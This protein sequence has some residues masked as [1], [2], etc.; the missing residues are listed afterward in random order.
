[1]TIKLLETLPKIGKG[2]VH[3]Q[4]VRCGKPHCRCRHGEP[5]QAFYLFWRVDGKLR[6]RHIR[7]T[8]VDAIR[9]ACT[10]RRERERRQRQ[11]LRAW[12]GQ[13]SALVA[14]LREVERHD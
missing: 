1:V 11:E 14:Q 13:Y 7:K 10:A 3:R 4:W 12:R 6:K 2:T 9:A 5:H 8:D